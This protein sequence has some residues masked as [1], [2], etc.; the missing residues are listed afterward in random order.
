MNAAS[1]PLRQGLVLAFS[2]CLA[3]FLSLQV[4]LIEDVVTP[5]WPPTGIAVVC[6]LIWGRRLWPWVT[7]AA[8][9]VNLSRTPTP[10]AALGLAAGNTLAPL[11]GATLLEKVRFDPE[12]SKMRDAVSLVFL[13]A[14]GSMT[15]SATIGTAILRNSG[16]VAAG[17][18]AGTW[19]VW[20][21]GD[22]LGVLVFVPLVLSFRTRERPSMDSSLRKLE[23]GGLVLGLV[24]ASA[25]VFSVDVP[26]RYLLFPLL[27]WAAL[28]F[29]I[30]GA[31]IGTL[32]V[33][34]FAVAS[35]VGG[36]DPLAAGSLVERML[37]LQL[38]N[39][40]AA[41]T[42][43]L[44]AAS[45]SIR[46]RA[47][48]LL[49]GEASRLEAAV[50]ERTAALAAANLALE[51]EVAIRSESEAHLAERE[52]LLNEAE[53]L[54]HVGS[55]SW[56]IVNDQISWSD[57][58]FRIY[59]LDKQ[60]ANLAYQKYLTMQ[61]PDD[62][63]SLRAKVEEAVRH[64]TPYRWDH[65]IVRSDG[66]VRWVRGQ[67]KAVMGP[68]G[69]I[70][71]YG[72]AQDITDQKLAEDRLRES[73]E[74]Y[75]GLVEQAP[76]AILVLDL[77]TGEFVE[78][79]RA[80]ETLLG[81]P[82]EKLVGSRVNDL[83]APVQPDGRPTS[84]VG[85]E[86]VERV[87]AGETPQFEWVLRHS[88]GREILVEVRIF[89]LP[90][91]G[92]RLVRGSVIDITEKRK[93]EKELL[94][95]EARRRQLVEQ[96]HIAQTLQRSLLPA[97]LPDFPGVGLSVRYL[98][99]SEGLEVGGDF[100][101]A[102]VLP[103]GSL[104]L[105]VGDIVGRGLLA[106]ATMGQLRTAL[107][108][109]A[110]HDPSPAA[111]LTH[112]S[113]LVDN[114]LD[115]EMATLVYA[116]FDRQTGV[117]TYSSAGHPPPL[118]VASNG[119]A[120]Y[121]KGA[122]SAP[123]GIPELSFEEATVALE[124]GSVLVLYTDGLIERR[125]ISIDD[126]LSKLAAAASEAMGSAG[127]LE[128]LT[129]GM[130]AA[131]H[132]GETLQDDTALLTMSV[133]GAPGESFAFRAPAEPESLSQ[134]RRTFSRWLAHRGA[135]EEEQQDLVLAVTEAAANSVLHAYRPG[136]GTFRV[137]AGT[138][139]SVLSVGVID[140]G[141]WRTRR[142][143][144]G[145]R[146]LKL[147]RALVSSV[148]IDS[149]ASGTRVRLQRLLGQP[150]PEVEAPSSVP[151]EPEPRPAEDAVA[152]VALEE[153]IDIANSKQVA[154]RLLGMLDNDKIGLVVDLSRLSFLDSSGLGMLLQL[155]RRLDARRMQLRIVVPEGS[156]IAQ[157]FSVAEV[158][159]V[160]PL[161]GSV[162]EAISSIVEEEP[163]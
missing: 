162:E 21:A 58:L 81:L 96:K 150:L 64:G 143:R 18:T 31:S 76:E 101:D 59:G 159:G 157:V 153:D 98:P 111:V 70:R 79:N 10:L 129:S 37:L 104:A 52:R 131:M 86:L 67:A 128:E 84:E 63:E 27:A 75:R 68:H 120:T 47:S 16:V 115:A 48:E 62:V 15:V 118:L 136:E 51:D 145:G 74:R 87:L 155:D 152:V 113:D 124:P 44:L 103:G 4:A 14:L 6:L 105:V 49:R 66:E 163:L 60:D 119:T 29:G 33:T 149:D 7:A 5:I 147:I 121:L 45:W 142:A 141:S 8:F 22:A 134:L 12:F 35:A 144:I 57:E 55:W 46:H 20:W 138:D 1:S 89:Y 130:L 91:A 50:Q 88:S 73:E 95:A 125:G 90:S 156:P 85:E 61:H 24:A 43:F 100:Y 28:R 109:Y 127:D 17:E 40:S 123:M 116:V 114:L 117:L 137:E 97:G 30:F 154:A 19:S 23:A 82:R 92:R 132:G 140:H 56:D 146:G 151:D 72:A 133:T 3:A 32:I 13:A 78:V 9:A 106:A 99:G 126:G 122:R 110:L 80:A 54:A 135:S 2:Y 41:L 71:L 83:V 107:R 108:A 34:G 77:D 148:S 94:Q 160:L 93:M 38:I 25:F 53:S 112:L 42:S 102:F 36:S 139:D 158:A 26:V 39:A 161:A 69:A 65:R 11:L